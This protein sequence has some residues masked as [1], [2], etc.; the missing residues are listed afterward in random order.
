MSLEHQVQCLTTDW[1]KRCILCQGKIVNML[2]NSAD[3]TQR[4]GSKTIAENLVALD[5]ISCLPRTRNLSRLDDGQVIEAVFR[6]HK[7]KWDDSCRL[8]YKKTRTSEA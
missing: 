3:V 8:H 4:E 5:K 1:N 6:L 2:N 7:A